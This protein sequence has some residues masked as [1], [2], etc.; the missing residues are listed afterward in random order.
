MV[1]LLITRGG[2]GGSACYI[3]PSSFALSYCFQKRI[4]RFHLFTNSVDKLETE[5]DGGEGEALR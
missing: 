3:G 5:K 2:S 1:L 4:G